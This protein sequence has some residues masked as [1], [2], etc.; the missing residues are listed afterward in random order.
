MIAALGTRAKLVVAAAATAV[1]GM[2]CAQPALPRA[3]TD[4]QAALVEQIARL[5][6]DGGPNAA[7]AIDP[8]RA[9]ALQYQEAGD[10]ALAIVMFE[11]ARH[12]TRVNQ[13]LTSADE[14]LLMRQQVRSEKALDAY[15]RAWD[16]EQEMLTIARQHHD[17]IRMAQVFRG[18]A[19]DRADVLKQYRGGH[20]PPEIYLGCYYANAPRPY[21]D[22]RGRHGSPPGMDGSCRSGNKLT[23]YRQLRTEILM[24]YADA[25]YVLVKNGDFASQELRSLEHAAVRFW[26]YPSARRTGPV[27]MGV[28]P[29]TVNGCED[30]PLDRLL[31]SELLGTCLDPIIRDGSSV[32]PNVGGWV[33]LVRLIA[34]EVRSGSPPAERAKAIADFADWRLHGTPAQRRRFDNGDEAIGLYERAYR[35]LQQGADVP[36]A[37]EQLF[38]PELPI[39]LLSFE[40]NPFA[41]TQES[42]R[43]IDVAFAITKYGRAEQI[44]IL[45]TSKD[46]TRGERRDLTR[47][48]E[49][50][51]FRPRVVNGAL[52]AAAPVTIRYP[53][54][55]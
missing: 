51:S 32:A 7:G 55:P 37:T 28:P 21:G 43:Y 42:Q 6:A 15:E 11:D 4:T 24:Y 40:P 39:T 17:D 19:E 25:I 1:S 45:D 13:G 10:D 27:E 36:V 46:V 14:A 16:L 31:E 38:A 54:A 22:T 18:L 34:Y 47:L 35:E 12:V 20:L 26:P 52:A 5:R 29:A 41:A 9:L 30:R 8:L 33:S 23:A 49:L 2:V 48:I 44:E 50:S 53:L 3:T